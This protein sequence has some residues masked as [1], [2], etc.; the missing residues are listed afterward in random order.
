VAS[1]LGTFLL[2]H[3]GERIRLRYQLLRLRVRERGWSHFEEFRTSVL[4]LEELRN[5][6]RFFQGLKR[7]LAGWRAFHTVLAI[8]LVGMIALHIAVSL[9]LGYRWIFR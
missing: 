9:F 5:Q 8:F 3:P 7:F 2:R 1:S 6:I 4:H